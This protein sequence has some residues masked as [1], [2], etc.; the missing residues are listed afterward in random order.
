MR[1]VFFGTPEIAVPAL[2]AL[3]ST[4]E[5]VAVVCQP[6]RP[7]G[8]GL[9]MQAPAVKSAATDLGIPVVQPAKVRTPDFAAWM[10]EQKADVAVVLAYGRILP[11]AILAAPAHGCINLHASILPK[12]RGA[13]PI[14]WAVVRGESSTG[15]SVM[16][17]DE[18]LDTGPVFAVRAIPILP[19]ETAGELAVRLA[20]LGALCVREDLPRISRGELVAKPQDAAK[21]TLAPLLKKADGQI[22]WARNAQEI[23]DHVRG[24]SPWPSAFTHVGGKLLK[25]LA[26]RRSTFAKGDAA[27]GAVV[28]ADPDATLVACAD[29]LIEI[30]RAQLEGKKAMGARDLV[31][32]RTLARGAVLGR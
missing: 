12:Y 15:M 19:D 3:A 5:V 21:A 6:D 24:M 8:R 18:G 23:H 10:V 30:V 27:P 2:R 31:V 20:L 7:A 17:M 1:A 4:T 11:P 13:A 25:I 32:G 28:V 29:G 9:E 26:T 14:T 16:Q 22:D